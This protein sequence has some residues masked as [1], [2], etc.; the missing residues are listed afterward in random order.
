[1]CSS[2]EIVVV[3][4]FLSFLLP[5]HQTPSHPHY[6]SSKSFPDCSCRWHDGKP[7]MLPAVAIPFGSIPVC[8][9]K[10]FPNQIEH[11]IQW[12]REVFEG[13]FKNVPSEV[14]R[15]MISDGLLQRC[16]SFVHGVSRF[17]EHCWV[18]F[19]RF[20]QVST[21]QFILLLAKR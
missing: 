5:S 10:S 2:L 19:D 16:V 6:L 15:W 9:V 13:A 21:C 17:P 11:T 14:G 18:K 4:M 3:P 1:M 8:T 7:Y 20:C 12:A